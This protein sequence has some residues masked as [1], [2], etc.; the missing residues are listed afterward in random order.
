MHSLPGPQTSN[1]TLRRLQQL[2][3]FIRRWWSN[4]FPRENFDDI[5]AVHGYRNAGRDRSFQ[6]AR[7]FV[8]F[9]DQLKTERL[10]LS[11]QIGCSHAPEPHA[12]TIRLLKI[13]P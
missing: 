2:L 13:S 8:A 3:D 1:H 12:Q 10:P 6:Y 9:A 7:C 11:P 4:A 5:V